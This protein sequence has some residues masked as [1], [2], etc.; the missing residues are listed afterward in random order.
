MASLNYDTE[1]T[2]FKLTCLPFKSISVGG[3]KRTVKKM[4]SGDS[5]VIQCCFLILL[6]EAIYT[7]VSTTRFSRLIQLIGDSTAA[8]IWHIKESY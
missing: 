1:L 2:K 5:A 6:N 4:L 8:R 7:I 3:N